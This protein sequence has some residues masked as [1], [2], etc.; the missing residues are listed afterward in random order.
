MTNRRW[1][2]IEERN[3]LTKSQIWE[4][5]QRQDGMCVLCPNRL[6]TKGHMPVQ[7]IDEHLKP[8][9]MGGTNEL[10]NRA[11]V[12]K[13]CATEKTRKEAT[14]RAKV[15]RVREKHTGTGKQ[16]PSGFSQR[17]KRK[18]D[19]TVVDRLTGEVIGKRK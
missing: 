8:L 19:G 6:E 4:M 9:W 2:P 7:F 3:R 12:C 5:Y 13:P 17:Y 16:K 14:V 11:L 10:I 15:K 1:E 18:M